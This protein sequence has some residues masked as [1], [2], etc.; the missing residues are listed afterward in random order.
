MVLLWLVAAVL[1][2][3]DLFGKFR[4]TAKYPAAFVLIFAPHFP[5]MAEILKGTLYGCL[6]YTSP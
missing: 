2:L 4:F 1:I 5:I 3:L 6:L